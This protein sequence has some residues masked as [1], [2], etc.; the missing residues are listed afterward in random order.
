ML[1][2]IFQNIPKLPL[3]A[4]IFYVGVVILSEFGY[5][6]SPNS[7]LLFLENLYNSYGLIGL[8]LA[9]FWKE[10]FIS[11]YISQALLSLPSQ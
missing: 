10:L 6:P 4:L 3:S 11:V 2:Q 7:V 1:K 5:I 9:S 8:F